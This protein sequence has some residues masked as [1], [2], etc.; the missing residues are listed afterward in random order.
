MAR[1]KHG[2]IGTGGMAHGH[3]R[4]FNQIR[5]VEVFG[6]FDVVPDRAAAFAETN[7]VKHAMPSVDALLDA[8]DSVSIV[9]PDAYHAALSLQTLK[10]GKHLFCEK[11]LTTTLADA[12]EVARAAKTAADKHGAVHLVNFSYR[13]SSAFQKAI[14]LAASGKLGVVRHATGRYF[15]A[16]LASTVWGNPATKEAWLWRQQVPPGGGPAAGGTL[17]DIGC[18]ILD[19]TTAVAGDVKALRC[20]TRTFPKINPDTGEPYRRYRGKK[21]D[22]ND[23]V[24]IELELADGGGLGSIEA[25]RWATGHPNQ[26]A[27]GVYG[28]E[29]A[30]E[31]DLEHSTTQLRTC[32]GKKRHQPQWTELEVKP[33]PDLYQR[34]ATS[35]KTGRNDQP[36]V[37]RGAQ[38]QAYLD[39]CERSAEDGGKR[40]AIGKWV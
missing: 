22:A 31:I 21:L 10:A 24:L 5:G 16:W 23:S 1:I 40:V 11:P 6:C 15:Q 12:R 20:T 29:G 9:T 26:V 8:C 39:A 17:G 38:I 25:T 28:T 2:I 35:I 27:L 37:F 34:F 18:H 14:A 4:R 36:D 30:L 3:A 7:H 19:F 32:L 13:N 33:T